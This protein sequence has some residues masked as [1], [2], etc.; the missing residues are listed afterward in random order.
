MASNSDRVRMV[1]D[2]LNGVQAPSEIVQQVQ[3]DPKYESSSPR[4]YGVRPGLAQRMLDTRNDLPKKQFE[5]L[6][7]V[8]AIRGLGDDTLHDLFKSITGASPPPSGDPSR[9]APMADLL[10]AAEMLR[11]SGKHSG[12]SASGSGGKAGH[13]LGR[14]PAHGPVDSDQSG[15]GQEDTDARD[16]A[17]EQAN[18]TAKYGKGAWRIW[19]PPAAML[20]VGVGTGWFLRGQPPVGPSVVR[21]DP[22]FYTTL[23]SL[24]NRNV[25]H[26]NDSALIL[27]ANALTNWSPTIVVTGGSDARDAGGPLAFEHSIEIDRLAGDTIAARC[28]MEGV[29]VKVESSVPS[30]EPSR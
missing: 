27:L 16:D 11:R 26:D 13:R 23:D 24:V 18:Q 22:S 4:A 12:V 19:L 15:E 25:A 5:S 7:Q 28:L 20:V 3:D 30:M 9:K 2:F 8:E 14:T 1:L 21:L 10:M 6:A 29:T 17:T